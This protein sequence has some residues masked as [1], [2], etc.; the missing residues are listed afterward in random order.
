MDCGLREGCWREEEEGR[1]YE[2]ENVEKEAWSLSTQG[3]AQAM[4]FQ[5]HGCHGGH[6]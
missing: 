4:W 6:G 5:G 1:D 3:V 2:D